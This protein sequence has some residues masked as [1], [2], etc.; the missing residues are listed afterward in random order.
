MNKLVLSFLLFWAASLMFACS[1]EEKP[2]PK[3]SDLDPRGVFRPL[4]NETDPDKIDNWFTKGPSEKVEGIDVE[5][6][7]KTLNLN[8]NAKS[9]TVAVIDGGF[10][11]NHEDLKGRMWVNQKE[12][13]GLQGVDDDQNGYIDDI[14]GWNFLGAKD[15]QGRSLNVNQERLESTRELVR[16]KKLRATLIA[17][18]QGLQRFDQAYYDKLENEV[19]G[20]RTVARIQIKYIE[21][22]IARVQELFNSIQTKLNIPFDKLTLEAVQSFKATTDAEQEAKEALIVEFNSSMAKSVERIRLRLTQLQLSLETSLNENFNP[23][24]EI[25][26]DNPDD[27]SN[28]YYGNNDVTGPDPLHGTHVAGIIAAIRNNGV[29][30]NG[31]SPYAKI[32]AIRAVPN[33]DEYDKDIYFAVKYAVD[34][35]A[36]IINM[37]FGK[38]YSPHKSKLDEIF[39][40]AAQR[41]V[42]LVHASGNYAHNNDRR[43]NY[44]NRFTSSPNSNAEIRNWIEVSASSRYSTSAIVANFSNYGKE[45][46]DIFAP[47]FE[48]N[49]TAPNNTYMV[50]SGT[51][52]AAPV[53]AGILS[54]LMAQNLNHTPEQIRQILLR[55]GRDKSSLEVLKPGMGELVKFGELSRSGAVADNYKALEKLLKN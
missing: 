21:N 15:G 34:N 55:N 49:S 43:D 48:I 37:S 4:E 33:G 10:D 27:F 28:G 2:E 20:D 14:N 45:S 54:V 42:I 39:K 16:L 36:K 5:R 24:A 11:L 32:M 52:M 40:Y 47:G 1:K 7:Y 31:V 12:A 30:I 41:G 29:G 23:R 35:G 19:T 13:Q 53:V 22:A 3:P 25:I 8:P 50:L 51:S 9:I 46:V 18:G 26:K 38:R 17:T 6:A 44:P